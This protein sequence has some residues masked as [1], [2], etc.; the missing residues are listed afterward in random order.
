MM[1]DGPKLVKRSKLKKDPDAENCNTPV[2]M[3]TI[4]TSLQIWKTAHP[5]GPSQKPRKKS[6]KTTNKLKSQYSQKMER[7][8]PSSSKDLN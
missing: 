4:V 2:R 1:T 3:K 5:G 7:Q 8:Q 6:L